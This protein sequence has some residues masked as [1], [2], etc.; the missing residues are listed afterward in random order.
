MRVGRAFDGMCLVLTADRIR[1][2][3]NSY[4]E[5]IR[6]GAQ[7]MDRPTNLPFSSGNFQTNGNSAFED[8]YIVLVGYQYDHVYH[9]SNGTWS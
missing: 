6:P 5:E 1:T 7:A 3:D 2:P 9:P 8:R 4:A